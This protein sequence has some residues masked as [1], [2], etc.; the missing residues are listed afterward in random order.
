MHAEEGEKYEEETEN[1]MEC[2]VRHF[3]IYILHQRISRVWNEQVKKAAGAL[4][5]DQM[6]CEYSTEPGNRSRIT[7]CNVVHSAIVFR[8]AYRSRH[9][10]SSSMSQ[11][12]N[13]CRKILE[14]CRKTDHACFLASHALLIHKEC[15]IRLTAFEGDKKV[16]KIFMEAIPMCW[17][18]SKLHLFSLTHTKANLNLMGYFLPL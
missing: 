4:D 1:K 7:L 11:L 2:L 10:V 16:V 13:T 5:R 14:H 18:L 3:H 9:R 12:F 17:L 6:S 15:I 8:F